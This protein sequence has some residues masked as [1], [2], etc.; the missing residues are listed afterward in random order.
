MPG[1]FPENVGGAVPAHATQMS[2]PS[3]LE[4]R[5]NGNRRCVVVFSSFAARDYGPHAFSYRNHFEPHHPDVDLIFVKDAAN[6]WYNRVLH[7]LGTNVHESIERLREITAGYERLTVFGSSMGGY[8]SLLYGNVLGAQH[9]VALSPQ[10]LLKLPFPRF[11]SRTHRGA[12]ADLNEQPFQGRSQVDVFVGEDDLFDVY[13]VARLKVAWGDAVHLTIVPNVAH[14]VVKLFDDTGK[15]RHM[16]R[17]MCIDADANPL[18]DFKAEYALASVVSSLLPDEGFVQLLMQAVETFY[19]DRPAAL[20]LFEDLVGHA[21]DWLG[22][23]AKL[24]M[25]LYA[26]GQLDDAMNLFA[27]VAEKSATVDE[28][29]EVYAAAA[30]QSGE[31]DRAIEI[32]AA[33]AAIEPT[34]KGVFLTTATLLEAKGYAE[35][36]QECRDR[37]AELK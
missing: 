21:P 22:A 8:G 1:E 37:W 26:C 35:H 34:K 3:F 6:Q 29:Y 13:Q 25:V 31:P 30:V 23:K 5:R 19:R 2:Y 36:A 18:V 20:G 24:G 14:N 27:D 15:F 10:T 28:F 11:N 9:V 33:C 32:A 17:C 7:G 4:M 12:Y 16:V